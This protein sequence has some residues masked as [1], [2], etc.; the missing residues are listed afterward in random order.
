[1]RCAVE[2]SFCSVINARTH[3]AAGGGDKFGQN[4]FVT[5]L[6]HIYASSP[7]RT[8]SDTPPHDLEILP[9]SITAL[10]TSPVSSSRKLHYCTN[11]LHFTGALEQKGLREGCISPEKRA[12]THRIM[13]SPSSIRFGCA[14][15]QMKNTGEVWLLA[16]VGFG[17]R[18]PDYSSDRQPR[19]LC[20]T[21]DAASLYVIF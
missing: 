15:L 3:C 19:R 9:V 2:M 8:G 7:R 4:T 17:K 20:C 13:H 5:L 12:R 10:A 1:M 11:A 18:L 16:M 21:C 14:P 6:P